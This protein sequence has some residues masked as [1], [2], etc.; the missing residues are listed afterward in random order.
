MTTHA[1]SRRLLAFAGVAAGLVL[2]GCTSNTN[3][4][5]PTPTPT[6]TSTPTPT[7]LITV[8]G[9]KLLL[10]GAQYKFAGLNADAMLGC[11]DNEI[12]TDAELDQYFAGLNPHSMTRVWPYANTPWREVMPRIIAAAERHGQ[13]LMVT[14]TDGN[15]GGSQCGGFPLNMADTGPILNH[16][17]NI[18]PALQASPSVAIWEVCNECSIGDANAKNWNRAAT[19][20]IRQLAPKALVAIGGSTCYTDVVPLA[21]CIDT[22]DL[23]NNNLISI[24]E[25][26]RNGGG[27]SQWASVTE[28]ISRTLNKP[29]FVGETGFSGGGGDSGSN[30]GNATRMNQEWSAYLA[31]PECAGMLYWDFKLHHPENTTVSFGSPMWDAAASFRYR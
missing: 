21:K 2:A 14:L 12:P 13:Y 24:H 15:D 22:N 5:Q 31:R 17:N 3:N 16:I 28:Q 7:G 25:Y 8:Q 9:T 30:A 11:W 6:P 4:N 1:V 23:P 27:V 29:W 10:N 20:R 26:D 19:D 18:V